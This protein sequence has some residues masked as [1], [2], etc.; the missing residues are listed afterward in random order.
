MTGEIPPAAIPPAVGDFP[1]GSQ[2][3]S[4]RIEQLIGRGGM[5]VVYRASDVRLDRQVA[6]KVLSQDLA[7]DTAF[8]QRFILESRSAAA[9]DHPNVIPVFEAGEAEG[10]LFIAMRYVVGQDVRALVDREGKLPAARVVNIVVQV[11]SALDA[12]HAHGLI[13]RD[14]KP[15]NMLLAT[16][17]DGRSPDHVYLSD[18]GLSKQSL[19]TSSLTSTGQF[20]GTLDYM[21]PEQ[22]EGRTVDGRTDLYALGCAAFEM[23]VGDPPFRREQ[24][25]AVMW[26]QISAAPPSVRQWRPDL[27]PE[28]DKVL[29]R[30][31]AKSPADRQPTCLEF[32]RELHAACAPLTPATAAGPAAPVAPTRPPTELAHAAPPPVGSPPVRGA[33]VIGQE[34]TVTENTPSGVR[35]QAATG[36]PGLPLASPGAGQAGGP[37]PA[38][39]RGPVAGPSPAAGPGPGRAGGPGPT[40]QLYPGGPTYPPV[41]PPKRRSKALPLLFVLM[42]VIGLAAAA[43]VVLHLRSEAS[44]TPH[45]TTTITGTPSPSHTSSASTSP[46]QT[47]TTPPPPP[48]TT[49]RQ[50]V[51]AFYDAINAHQYRRAYEL[52]QFVHNTPFAT[53][54]QGYNTTQHVSVTF[55]STSSDV[56][57]ITLTALHTDGTYKY[58]QGSYTVQN[59]VIVNASISCFTQGNSTCP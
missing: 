9:V 6:L 13:H 33:A 54:K 29:A 30:A 4:Y 27:S 10:V 51:T 52:N 11:A 44:P 57:S 1:A 46:T 32:A 21:S 55:G 12:A 40:A 45:V 18:F 59:G 26:A 16:V 23:L 17:S 53:W 34:Q 28:V 22:I 35:G 24:N 43:L 58:Y 42:V 5:A 48:P 15:A 19:A 37:A 56:V 49:P 2:I 39:G 47:A 7:R 31:L 20:L 38:V 14:V 25:L 36:R 50:V 41:M 3:A 8:R